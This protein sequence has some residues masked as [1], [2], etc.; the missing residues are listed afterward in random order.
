MII[1]PKWNL[2][3]NTG[4]CK[5]VIFSR[6]IDRKYPDFLIDNNKI[7]V[8]RDFTYL[9]LKLNYNNRFS[10][11]QKDLYDRALRAMYLLMKKATN[12][13]LPIDVVIDLFDNTVL[14]VLTYGCEVWGFHSLDLIGKLQLKFYKNVL[15]LKASTPTL[16][17]LGEV[18]KYPAELHIKLRMLLFWHK[19]VSEENKNNL[20]S[21]IYRVLCTLHENRLIECNY[22]IYI[23]KLLIEIG[24]PYLW[25]NQNVEFFR[26]PLFKKYIKN[27][28][29]DLFIQ[30]WYSK[31]D[32]GGIYTIYRMI[33]TSFHRSPYIN[34]LNNNCAIAIARFITTN[35]NL[36]V[37]TNRYTEVERADRLCIKCNLKDIGDEFHYVFCCPF[38]DTKRKELLPKSIVNKQNAI[39]FG[40]LMN[41]SDR[42]TLLKLK[43]FICYIQ[44]YLE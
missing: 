24:L 20:S 26:K 22:I 18:G 38:F 16:M 30:Q 25:R 12:L 19:L 13:S 6:G 7:E 2:S 27:K 4:K 29:Q 33:K 34:V 10:V 8:V 28:L 43:H 23:E 31:I 5:I 3:L 9:G 42:N 41:E 1:E 21:V 44:N 37:N 35:N 17:V 14:P 36:P 15:K 39:S 32:D 11:A 40:R